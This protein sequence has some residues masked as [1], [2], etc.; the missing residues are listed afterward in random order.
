MSETY[1]GGGYAEYDEERTALGGVIL[2]TL[3]FLAT[4]LVIAG[5]I[6]WTGA[7]PRHNAAVLAA[8][9]EPTLYLMRLPC[10]TQQAVIS[11]YEATVNPAVKQLTA[12]TVAYRANERSRLVP[13]EA[14]LTSEVQT[15]QA[16]DNSLAAMAFTP[17]NRARSVALITSGSS[18]GNQNPVP[19][20][21]TFTPRMTV[22]AD[23]LIKDNQALIKLTTE[24]A[25][26][27][28][29]T[30]LRSFNVKTEA[31]GAVVLTEMKLLRNAV[32]APLAES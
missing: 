11:Q 14:A 4:I 22:V 20:A 18:T 1:A 15:E 32:H 28:S 2:V 5:L 13:A 31:A 21:I 29:L 23:A 25:R 12:D 26:S 17:E 27:S 30:Q 24:Q 8:G 9:C 16:L 3:S 10:I 6:Y 7:T 19:A